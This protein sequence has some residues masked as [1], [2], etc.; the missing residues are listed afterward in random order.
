MP[1]IKTT[2]D[3]H[4]TGL[5]ETI[6]EAA[7]KRAGKVFNILRIMSP[8]PKALQASLGLYTATMFGESELPRALRELLAVVV[9]GANDCFY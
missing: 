4:A 1:Y 6:F 7:R 3:D 2:D 5:L 8:S 9:S